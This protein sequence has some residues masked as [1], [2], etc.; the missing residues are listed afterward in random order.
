MAVCVSGSDPYSMGAWRVFPPALLPV[1]C[2]SVIVVVSAYPDMIPAWTRGAVFV[3]ADRGPKLYDDLR[4]GRYY[5]K[6]K[7]KQSG[8]NEFSHLVLLRL[9]RAGGWPFRE[10]FNTRPTAGLTRH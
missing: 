4:I 10:S 6:G 2:V 5:A 7:T 8:K 1:I 3:D 9:L